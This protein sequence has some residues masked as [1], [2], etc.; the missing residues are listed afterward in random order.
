MYKGHGYIADYKPFNMVDGEGVRNS[1][2]VSGCRFN[3]KGCFNK[4]TQNFRYGIPF[5]DELEKQIIEDLSHL[6]V[7]GLSLLGG[8]PF[9]NTNT[10]IRVIERVRE[11]YGDS[12]DIWVWT[13]YKFEDLK[14]AEHLKILNNV[15]VL[16]DGQFEIENKDLT[17]HYRGSSNQ[18]II[19]VKDSLQNGKLILWKSE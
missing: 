19:K 2:Y 18:R 10:V 15:D 8:E 1:I 11:V 16:I 5:I 6:Y 3:C 17:L 13:G 14:E 9:E 4:A 7:Q 12:K